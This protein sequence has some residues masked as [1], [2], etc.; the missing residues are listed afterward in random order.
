MKTVGLGGGASHYEYNSSVAY[1]TYFVYG[2]P[3]G[4]ESRHQIWIG[5]GS[6]L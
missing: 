5:D 6:S 3:N 1:D 2:R 4:L